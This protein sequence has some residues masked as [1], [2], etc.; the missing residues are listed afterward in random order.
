MNH[1]RQR[2]T[3]EEWA[4][5]VAYVDGELSADQAQAITSKLGQSVTA[6]R[7]LESL[8]RTWELLDHLRLPESPPTLLGQT[9]SRIQQAEDDID[10]RFSRTA[11]WAR[12]L[13]VSL[14][15]AGLCVAAAGAG[16]WATARLWPDRIARLARSLTLSE[17]LPEYRAIGSFERLQE[18]DKYPV[19]VPPARTVISG[20]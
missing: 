4:N 14:G 10:R 13:V 19:S 16:W 17:R 9:L 3:S 12:S 11:G 2:L 18:L 7:E 1:D 6:R 8:K 5:L 20:H 15:V